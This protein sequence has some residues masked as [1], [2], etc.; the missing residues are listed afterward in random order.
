MLLRRLILLAAPGFCLLLT[1]RVFAA[2]GVFLGDAPRAPKDISGLPREGEPKDVTAGFT[3]NTFSREQVRSFYNAVYPSSDNV[4]MDSTAVVS[5]CVPG[6]NSAAFQNAVVRR[7]NW[8]RAMAGVPA[9]VT[10]SSVD[11]ANNQAAALMMSANMALSHFPPTSWSCYTGSGANAASN[12]DL[13]IGTSGSDAITGYIWDFGANNTVVGHRRWILYPQTQVMGTGDV[14]Q[15][16]SFQPANSTWVFDSHIFGPRP[17]T[18]NAFVSWP[19]PGFV[20]YSLVFPQWSFGLSNADL[21][22]ATVSMQSNGVSVPVSI[23]SYETGVGENSIVWVPMGLDATSDQTMFPFAGPD[24]RYQITVTNINAGGK[25]IGFTYTS[26]L[27]DPATPGPDYVP[28]SVSGPAQAIVNTSNIYTTTAPVSPGVTGYQWIVSQSIPGNLFDGAENGLSNFTAELLPGYSPTASGLA[29][30]GTFSFH[31][32]HPATNSTD[33]TDQILQLNRILLPG[34]NAQLSF[35]SLLGFAT[36]NQV[37]EAQVSSDGGVTWQTIFSQAGTGSPQSA[38][39]PQTVSLSS[40]AGTS[41]LLRFNY[42]FISPGSYYFQ[43]SSSPPVGWF[44]DNILVTNIQQLINFS[45][46][47]TPSTNFAFNPPQPGAYNLQAQAVLFGQ[48]PLA[49]GSITQITTAAGAPQIAMGQP[50]ISNGLLTLPFTVK[51]GAAGSFH[52]FQSPKFPATWLTNTAAT[53]ATNAP[54][55]AY[56]FSIQPPASTAFFEVVSP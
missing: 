50:A 55:S 7:I 39:S 45:T 4:P 23:Q 5:N 38:F 53:L 11:S 30:S 6:T 12:S 1:L 37:S 16:G 9:N 14:P 52:L 31:L 3:V 29:A 19:P 36:S 41:L 35:Q 15:Q 32:A 54:G 10:L 49:P 44:I 17:P 13:A 47:T 18:S 21:S 2:G 34:A 43:T 25:I 46:N 42:H 33:P 20:P 8:F 26:T 22:G 51:G 27:F 40:F 56:T 48:F 28:Q 24:T